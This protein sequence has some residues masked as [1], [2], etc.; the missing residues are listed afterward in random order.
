[1]PRIGKSGRAERSLVDRS[2]HNGVHFSGESSL[3]CLGEILVACPTTQCR[4][5]P[6]HQFIVCRVTIVHDP[7]PVA[8]EVMILKSLVT[9][10]SR[11]Q[12]SRVDATM[13]EVRGRLQPLPISKHNQL[14][15]IDRRIT[16]NF[17]T[18]L[19]S[20][21]GRVSHGHG[22]SNLIWVRL[23]HADFIFH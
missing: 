2:G 18:Q 23:T 21:T 12:T 4:H 7:M 1:M 13:T 20:D 11:G 22:N 16:E 15:L 14:G 6:M 9:S 8:V 10:R 3:D 5:L 17:C 19:R